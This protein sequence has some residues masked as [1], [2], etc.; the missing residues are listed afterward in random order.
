MEAL[1]IAACPG[2]SAVELYICLS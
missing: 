1:G 2:R